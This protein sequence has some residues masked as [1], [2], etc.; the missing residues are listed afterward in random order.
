MTKR[1]FRSILFYIIMISGQTLFGQ[2]KEEGINNFRDYFSKHSY[3]GYSLRNTKKLDYCLDKLQ[4]NGSFSDVKA[5]EDEIMDKKMYS[6]KW[7]SPQVKVNKLMGDVIPR[8]WRISDAIKRNQISPEQR[9]AILTKL[10]KSINRYGN[11]EI[12]RGALNNGRFHTSCFIVPTAAVNSY[13]A[14]FSLMEDVENGINTDPE[15]IKANKTLLELSYQSWTQPYRNDATDKNVVSVERFRKHVWWVGGNALA[16]RSLLPAAAAMKSIPMMDVLCT[17]TQNA[18]STVAQ[19]TYDTDFWSEGFTAD[20]AGWGHGKQSIVWGYPI[21]GGIAALNLLQHF[22]GTAW[23]SKMSDQNKEVLLN[24]LRGSSWYY[25]KGYLPFGLSRSTMDYNSTNANIIKSKKIVDILLQKWQAS[26]TPSEIAE[27][28]AFQKSASQKKIQMDGYNDGIYDG[29][30]WFYNNDDL[31]KK[32]DDYY[33]YINTASRR[34][35]GTESAPAQADSYNFYTDLGMTLFQKSGNEYVQSIGAWN[36]TSVPGTTTRQNVSPLNKVTNWSGFCSDINFSGAATHGGANGVLGYELI[37]RDAS[38]K[39]KNIIFD[40]KDKNQFLYGVKAYKSYFIFG[41]YLLALG[42]NIQNLEKSKPG[43]IWTTIDQ[44]KLEASYST[45][46]EPGKVKESS[47]PQSIIF[48]KQDGKLIGAS[49]KD[50][51][52]YAVIPELTSGEIV[53][54]AGSKATQW[55]ERNY[56]NKNRKDLPSSA[57]IF[58]MYINHGQEV[59]D[60]TYAYIVYAGKEPAVKAF[61]AKPIDV[62]ENSKQIQA[63]ES[64]KNHIM[65]IVFHDKTKIFK[66]KGFTVESSHPAVLL[67]EETNGMLTFTANDPEMNPDC[68]EITLTVNGPL[69]GH[70]F[71]TQTIKI[72]LTVGHHAG[73]PTTITLPFTVGASNNLKKQTKKSSSFYI[74][75]STGSNTIKSNG[76]MTKIEVFSIMG[77]LINQFTPNSNSYVLPTSLNGLHIITV[78]FKDGSTK[79]EKFTL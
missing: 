47:V 18:I 20:G 48:N 8:I 75:T 25:Y 44:T 39:S 72:N 45:W 22:N 24:Y 30:R 21:D 46:E 11:I 68:K 78:T 53:L 57:N 27:L 17:V 66:H 54:E 52:A 26:F 35:D 31:I 64:K 63:A 16:Y 12:M 14:L 40:P 77:N 5:L 1:S 36:L 43:E 10:L 3:N 19:Q 2:T 41:D 65:G 60:A 32:N 79:T 73:K 4:D 61:Q 38:K 51:F 49:Q 33:I 67:I 74:E 13:F 55:K 23:S 70:T 58:H 34:T 9:E 56:R 15:A 28:Q 62:I 50:K 69:W 76:S 6:S 59:T 7:Y 71:K 42:S 29:T 37:I